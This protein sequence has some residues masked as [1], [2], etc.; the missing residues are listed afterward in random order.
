MKWPNARVEMVQQW[1]GTGLLIG[2]VLA[3]YRA[4]SNCQHRTTSGPEM[5]LQWASIVFELAEQWHSYGFE[6][7]Q[8]WQFEMVLQWLAH[9]RL[10]GPEQ[11]C[12]NR[13][14]SGPSMGLF[15]ALIV[16]PLG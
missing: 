6:M 9:R 14:G 15:W 11:L 4:I 7:A 2:V 12:Q 1:F 5:G 13:F 3:H 8:C 10:T 16:F